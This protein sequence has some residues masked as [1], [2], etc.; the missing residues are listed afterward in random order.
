MK[1]RSESKP[2]PTEL[3]LGALCG[4][5]ACGG[6]YQVGDGKT[7]HPPRPG[8]RQADLLALDERGT[9]AQDQAAPTKRGAK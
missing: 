3:A 5:F 9:K 4:S 7:I 6:C 2:L 1:P 8:Y